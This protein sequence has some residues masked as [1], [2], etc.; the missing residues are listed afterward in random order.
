MGLTGGQFTRTGKWLA[1][2]YALVFI[3]GWFI[4]L[5]SG[6]SWYVALALH[7]WGSPDF[8][9]WQLLTQA[10]V[11]PGAEPLSFILTLYML[12]IFGWQVE[13][14]YGRR[15]FVVLAIGVPLLAGVV[16]Y[17]AT[18]LPV[19]RAPLGGARLVLDALVVAYALRLRHAVLLFF[20]YRI[21]ALQ[22]IWFLLGI[23]ALLFLT[24]NN[25]FFLY[26]VLAMAG[27]WGVVQMDE[28]RVWAGWA[29]RRKKARV[30]RM[31]RQDNP[32]RDKNN[33][34][35]RGPYLH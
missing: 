18:I 23:N 16:G 11:L 25:P 20:S 27:A 17:G 21:R 14:T 35:E 2:W 9:F 12:W 6:Y 34:S 26:E 4:K 24:G 29:S 1:A 22:L 30:L 5:D 8:H 33:G 7:P 32:P 3:T 15:I 13:G 10:V 31:P 28:R 19:F